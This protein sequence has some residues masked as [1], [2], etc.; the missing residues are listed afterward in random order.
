MGQYQQRQSY[1]SQSILQALLAIFS[2]FL[3]ATSGLAQSANPGGPP[4]RTPKPRSAYE[5]GLDALLQ[6]RKFNELFQAV[7]AKDVDTMD[8]AL[9]WLGIQLLERGQ[10]SPIGYLYAAQLWRAGSSSPGLLGDAYKQAAVTMMVMSRWMIAT[11]GFQCADAA[12]PANRLRL[13][14]GG[15]TT[16][17]R[18][19]QSLDQVHRHEV[20]KAAFRWLGT[21][22]P[23]RVD[24][25][26]LCNGGP[27]YAAALAAKHGPASGGSVPYDPEIRAE[28]RPAAQWSAQREQALQ[29][30]VRTVREQEQLDMK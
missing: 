1:P 29:D 22:Y 24:D 10:G 13:I 30:I 28:I 17:D 18:Y 15:F 8:R 11:E 12:S 7:S 6:Q 2:A 21:R 16:L 5:E 14:N 23:K 9:A 25:E 26:W 3:L 27:H 20:L 19:Y 4:G